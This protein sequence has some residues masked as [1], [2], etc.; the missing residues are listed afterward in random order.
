M[1][2][3]SPRFLGVELHC[4][5]PAPSAL[6]TSLGA[7]CQCAFWRRG[8]GPRAGVTLRVRGRDAEI[9]VPRWVAFGARNCPGGEAP[10]DCRRVLGPI[11]FTRVTVGD[12]N[13]LGGGGRFRGR[14]R[15]RAVAGGWASRCVVPSQLPL[16]FQ[17]IDEA[18]GAGRSFVSD[19]AREEDAMFGAEGS[20]AG[21]ARALT[22][23]SQCFN[24][25]RLARQRPAPED[26]N[27]LNSLYEIL[28]PYLQ[29]TPWPPRED[30][31]N[32]VRA[33][34]SADG[35]SSQYLRMAARVRSARCVVGVKDKWFS[36]KQFKVSRV[37]AFAGTLALVSNLFEARCT[38]V[39][40]RGNPDGLE[41]KTARARA[42]AMCMR[43][44][45]KL[46]AFLDERPEGFPEDQ[47]EGFHTADN[48]F[49]YVPPSFWASP[50]ALARCGRPERLEPR[51]ARK[52]RYRPG[53]PGNIAIF[54]S[55]GALGKVLQVE[56]I[57]WVVDQSAISS[58]IDMNPYF[59][60]GPSQQSE[61]AWHMARL[62]HRCRS[63]GAAEAYCER[64]GSYMKKV[65]LANPRQNAASFMNS[66]YLQAAGL[67]C[68]GS[69]RD[70]AVVREVA[71]TM[72]SLGRAPF[73]RG[74][75]DAKIAPRI[76]KSICKKTV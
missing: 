39:G 61:S 3:A 17:E 6:E 31:P 12:M 63:F 66:V 74:R 10:L 40:P 21:Y 8:A 49:V 75:L 29:R 55:P 50:T 7:H 11:R 59:A 71:D 26:I 37:G 27:A 70:E 58:S 38:V 4:G 16:V 73:P 72:M 67:A 68:V 22:A 34:P 46:S 13:A 45:N 56:E 2:A 44:A 52:W 25:E 51:A 32:V 36:I 48:K 23:M 60:R 69:E 18:I 24:W 65:W 76:L 54:R 41:P 28:L 20:S 1:L 33:W 9:Q 42:R 30:F 5:V 53:G 62:H 14:A 47:P 43:I 64:I 15:A 57:S 19:F 35:M